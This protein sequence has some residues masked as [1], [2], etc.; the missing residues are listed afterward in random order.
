MLKEKKV[1]PRWR[2]R[3]GQEGRARQQGH[4]RAGEKG[5]GGST[6]WASSE[7]KG[8]CAGCEGST[9]FREK[10]R[11][12]LLSTESGWWHQEPE[13]TRPPLNGTRFGMTRVDSKDGTAVRDGGGGHIGSSEPPLFR[14]NTPRAVATSRRDPNELLRLPGVLAARRVVL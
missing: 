7:D 1:L 13:E 9:M 10:P 2:T 6:T 5:P 8:R 4:R 14:G 3:M 11:V 12:C